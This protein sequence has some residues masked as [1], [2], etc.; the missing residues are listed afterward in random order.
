MTYPIILN[1]P[2]GTPSPYHLDFS[3]AFTGLSKFP[4]Y[5]FRLELAPN[6][7]LT[8]YPVETM[9]YRDDNFYVERVEFY[10]PTDSD[11]K[12]TDTLILIIKP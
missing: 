2:I 10:P 6:T 11:N 8:D 3:P 12:T 7:Y 4:T 1:I 5:D 9:G